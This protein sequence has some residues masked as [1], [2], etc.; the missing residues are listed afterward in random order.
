MLFFFLRLPVFCFLFSVFLFRFFFF[1][2]RGLVRG[3]WSSMSDF[4]QL[5]FRFCFFLLFCCFAFFAVLLFLLF[6][7]FDFVCFFVFLK[8]FVWRRSFFVTE[9]RSLQVRAPPSTAPFRILHPPHG[10]GCALVAIW[11]PSEMPCTPRRAP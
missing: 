8:F 10:K 2:C 11:N 5:I 4:L 9:I 6:C 3:F 7:S 1:L